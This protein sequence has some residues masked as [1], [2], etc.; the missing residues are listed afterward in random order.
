MD[1]FL[2]TEP[3]RC[4]KTGQAITEY[5]FKIRMKET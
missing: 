1:W 2:E 5:H 3:G 4:L